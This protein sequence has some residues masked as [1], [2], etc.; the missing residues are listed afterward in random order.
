MAETIVQ[1]IVPALLAS[2]LILA[3]GWGISLEIRVANNTALR[4]RVDEMDRLGTRGSASEL[5]GV[6][7]VLKNIEE[8]NSEQDRILNAHSDSLAR[9]HDDTAVL[10]ANQ[11]TVLQ[12]QEDMSRRVENLS[13]MM[14]EQVRD[15]M[16]SLPMMGPPQQTPPLQLQRPLR[17]SP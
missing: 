7:A 16:P 11:A 3:V 12:R 8:H 15:R 9:L 4:S 13:D 5:V 2:F 1:R 14:H 17:P 10:K 6:T